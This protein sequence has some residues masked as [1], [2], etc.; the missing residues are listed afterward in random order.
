MRVLLLILCLAGAL[1]LLAAEW[2]ATRVP[3]AVIFVRPGQDALAGNM[4]TMA[5]SELPRLAKTIGVA[6]PGPFPIFAYTSYTDFLQATG[7]DPYLL[8]ISVSPSGKI[9]LDARGDTLSVRRTLAHELTHSLL[10]QRLGNHIGELPTWVNE[11][12]AGFLADPESPSELPAVSQ[13]VHGSGVL[14]LDELATAFASRSARD[15]AYLQSRSM[16][17]WL[18]YRHPGALRRV[19]DGLA[20]G[21]SFETALDH[22]A[23]LTPEA[24]WQQW[25]ESIPAYMYWLTLLGSPVIFAPVALLVVILAILRLRRKQEAMVEETEDEAQ[26]VEVSRVGKN[27][28][29]HADDPLLEDL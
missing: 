4:A 13:L 9:L 12:I 26:G 22:A 18:E 21:E 23:Q 11:G 19:I 27:D 1:P 15:A 16:S 2:T 25:K 24:W 6:A 29:V 28:G 3:G 8:G 14:T 20:N 10:D 5:K 7:V 17:A